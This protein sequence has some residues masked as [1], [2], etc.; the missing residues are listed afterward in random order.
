MSWDEV[1]MRRRTGSLTLGLVIGVVLIVAYI[2]GRT[3]VRG[4]DMGESVG[5]LIAYAIMSIV[6]TLGY[7]WRESQLR[8]TGQL[9]KTLDRG[10]SPRAIRPPTMVRIGVLLAVAS[11]AVGGTAIAL[12]SGQLWIAVVAILAAFM[13]MVAFF[14]AWRSLQT[15]EDTS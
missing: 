10:D 8:R 4:V 14:T 7:R 6:A 12:F 3:I 13:G 5:L 11:V 2:L 9:P 1:K 15:E